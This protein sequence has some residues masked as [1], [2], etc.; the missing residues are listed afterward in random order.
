MS[1]RRDLDL[2]DSKIKLFPEETPNLKTK[3]SVIQKISSERTIT[4]ILNLHCDLDLKRS[5]AIFPQ[6]TQFYVT[7]L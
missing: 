3:Y 7:V 4:G 5:N 2:D 6:D 1:S